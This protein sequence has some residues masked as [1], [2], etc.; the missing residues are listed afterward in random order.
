MEDKKKL[1]LL[2][3]NHLKSQLSHG[4]FNDESLESMEVAVQCI[5]SAYNLSPTES[6][7][8]DA[9][10]ESI[11]KEYYQVREQKPNIKSEISQA[12]KEEAENQKK[13]GNEFMK[14][15]NNDKAIE[16]YTKAIKLNPLNPIY[17]CNRAAAFNAIGK[18]VNAIEDCQKAIELDSSYCKAYC[19]LG[20]AFS[21]LKDYHKAVSCYKKACELDPDNQGYQRNYQLTLNNLQTVSGSPFPPPPFG[22]PFPPPPPPAQM[23]H[24]PITATPNLM[25]TAARIMT[26]N[27]EVSSVLNNILGDVT[28]TGSD[29]LDRLMQVG[30]TIVTRLQTA[31]PDL[32][33]G[34]RMQFQNAQNEGQPPPHNGYHDDE[35]QH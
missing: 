7:R 34:L 3:V 12:Q 27:P 9:K 11:V 10:L 2:I 5:E 24:D 4:N 6:D 29:G 30:Q 26:D 33:D 25:E 22:V 35:P 28:S 20:L 8:V 14:T 19:R 13:F 15:Q 23:L 17:Y 21:Y 16:A 31:N 32:L 18:Y 1:A